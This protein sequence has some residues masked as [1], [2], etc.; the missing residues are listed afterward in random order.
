MSFFKYTGWIS[1]SIVALGAYTGFS[2]LTAP[3][4]VPLPPG[5]SFY[6]FET[7]SYTADVYKKEFHPTRRLLDYLNFLVFFPHLVAGPIRRARQLLPI[8]SEYRPAITSTIANQALIYIVWGL[9]LKIFCADNMGAIVENI[10]GQIQRQGSL[11][12]GMGLLFMYAFAFQ[13]YCDFAGYSLIA[14]GSALLFG[15]EIDRNFLTPYFSVN[16]SEFW[17]RWHI[18]LSSWLRDYVYISLGGNQHG[19]VI[20]LRNLLIVMFLVGLWHGAGAFF[21]L[22]GLWHGLLLVLYRI[23]PIDKWLEEMFGALG[24]LVAIIVFFHLVCFGWILFRSNPGTFW[25]IVHSILQ[26]QFTPKRLIQTLLGSSV[27]VLGWTYL[28]YMLPVLITDLVGYLNKCEFPD[29]WLTFNNMTKVLV[30]L[31]V[32]YAMIWFGARQANEFIYFAF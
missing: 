20:T 1:E 26:L 8:L 28:V 11:G 32:V 14:R 2:V 29:L 27:M 24:R 16:P 31:A 15:V 17:Q 30:L 19:T 13:I 12:A 23:V 5:V 18:S 9:F 25:P 3:I 22:W 21:I 6:T 4:H 7:I 10:D